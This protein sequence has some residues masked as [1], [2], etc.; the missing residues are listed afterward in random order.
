MTGNQGFAR[1]ERLRELF[2]KEVVQAIAGLKDPG[3][4]GF[5]TVTDLDL[6][7]NGK[8][9]RVFY[10]L[11]GSSDDRAS[12]KRALER[13]V[14]FIRQKL[15]SKLRFKFI[16]KLSFEFDV[17]PEGAQRIESILDKIR[18]EDG[19]PAQPKPSVVDFERLNNLGSRAK[20][21]RRRKRRRG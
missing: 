18:E 6:S 21:R 10:S 19:E 2:L 4:S 13:S 8:T 7:P 12:T 3:L 9:A 15:Y 1:S 16:P 20:P 11:L 17:T 14:N 5:L